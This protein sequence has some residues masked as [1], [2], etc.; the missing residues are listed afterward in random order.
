[1]RS[2]P[3]R[4][5]STLVSA[6]LMVTFLVPPE[7]VAQSAQHVV[8]PS[9][10]AKAAVD[11]SQTRQKNIDTLNNFLSTDQ[12]QKAMQSARMNPQEVKKAVSSLS[13]EDLAQLASRASKAQADFAAGDLGNRDLLIVILCIAALIL[14]I[15]AVR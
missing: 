11:A 2:S 1:M 5:A 3:L 4:F 15:V 14:V 13:D 9:D 7:S 12:A 6:A 10:L 8:S